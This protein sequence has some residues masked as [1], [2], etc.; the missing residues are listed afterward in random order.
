DVETAVTLIEDQ[1][2]DILNRGETHRLIRWLELLPEEIINQRPTLIQTKAWILRWQAKF[3]AIPPLLQQAEALVE[4]QT[5]TNGNANFDILAGERDA[6]RSEIAFFQ[7]D[8]LRCA[9]FG[10]SALDRL[11]PHYFFA[12]GLAALF[13]IA[14]QQNQGQ[15]EAALEKLYVWLD[16]DR[17]QH[18][19][20]RYCLLL[21][22]GGIYGMVGDLKH[23]EQIGQ[24]LLQAGLEKKHPL[25]TTWASHFLAHVYY[26][27][28]RLEEAAAHWSTVAKWPY[29]ANFL[30][31]HDAMLGL[32]LIDHS[33]GNV[34]QAQQTLDTLNQVMLE[35]NQNQFA[36]QIE[37]FRTRLALLR[38][39]VGTATHWL[40]NGAKPAFM[41]LFFWEAN[42]ITHIKAL[43]AQET[44]V[45]YQKA[46][47]LLTSVQQVAEETASVWL[48]I[49]MWALRALLAQAQDEQEEALAAAERAV[50]LAE[51]GG[52][53]RLFTELGAGMADL[54]A[55]LA[56]R[57]VAPA[58]IDRI[59]AVFRADQSLEADALTSRELEILALLQKGL[60]DKEIAEQL[61]LSVLTVK[62]HNRNIYQKLGVNG[63]RQAAAEAK[64]LNLLS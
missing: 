45:S 49:Q 16:D 33:Q 64:T 58:Y 23:L 41:S 17:F 19:A 43:M 6:L 10:Q 34:T 35:I 28:N 55:Q 46:A 20:I 44:A 60:S 24:H 53:L 48:L 4:T 63:R 9:T 27:W 15:T 14:G 51:P 2:H 13:I 39:E 52:Y 59:L 18:F 36:P 5:L 26:Q 40:Q 61:V 1:R 38:G 22:A 42:C 8:F 25:S 32:A 21:A 57:G 47:D 29:Q 3:Q 37:S 31:Y 62:K 56:A 50:C 54:L 30:A 11:P 7:N 12:R